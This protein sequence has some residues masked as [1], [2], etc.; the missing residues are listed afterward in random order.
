MDPRRVASL[1]SALRQASGSAFVALLDGATA[2]CDGDEARWAALAPRLAARRERW[3]ALPPR[4]PDV[5]DTEH[6]IV[7]V[8]RVAH[9]A[10]VM[11]LAP[12]SS[13]GLVRVRARSV[14]AALAA[15]LGSEDADDA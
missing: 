6:G 7:I 4:E 14:L 8:E 9:H 10:A 2:V 15:A 3:P 1:L 12:G 11:A 13:I 5:F